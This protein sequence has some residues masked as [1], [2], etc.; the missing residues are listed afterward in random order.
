MKIKIKLKLNIDISYEEIKFLK[1]YFYIF[2]K[3]KS[4]SKFKKNHYI[5][6]HF[7]IKKKLNFNCKINNCFKKNKKRIF[8]SIKK[9]I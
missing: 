6:F 1:K 2:E 8:F 9:K 5:I 3:I 4:K 7:F